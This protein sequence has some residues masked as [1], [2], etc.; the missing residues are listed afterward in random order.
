GSNSGGQLGSPAGVFRQ[1]SAGSAHTCAVRD[2]ATVACWGA[3]A[4]GQATPPAGTFREVEAG[5][6]NTCAVRSDGIPVCW[7]RND[8]GQSPI[9][10][11]EPEALPAA[12]AGAPY[13]TTITA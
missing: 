12:G 3:N 6:A 9:V 5:S 1:L 2:D 10:A 11:I 7:G 8:A 4:D 13:S